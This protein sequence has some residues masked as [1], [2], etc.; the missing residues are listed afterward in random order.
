MS[1]GTPESKGWKQ[2]FA[3]TC[4]MEIPPGDRVVE[5]STLRAH[6]N[7]DVENDYAYDGEEYDLMLLLMIMI[8]L[9]EAFTPING[10]HYDTGDNASD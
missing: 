3:I 6:D 9:L 5:T 1:T 10:S 2:I 7:V 8:Y 4:S